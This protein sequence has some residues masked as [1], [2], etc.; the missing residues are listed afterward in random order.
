[1]SLC[2]CTTL[3]DDLTRAQTAFE[4]ARYEDAEAWLT[5]L[6]PS[7]PKFEPLDR[8]RYYYLAGMSAHRIGQHAR[9]RHAL[10]LCR[11]ELELAHQKLSPAWMQNLETALAKP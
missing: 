4:Q 6:E 2:S 1:M 3:N 5:D 11:E 9:A 8:A 10:A 7:L